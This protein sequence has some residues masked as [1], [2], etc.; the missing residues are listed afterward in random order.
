VFVEFVCMCVYVSVHVHMFVNLC[1]CVFV[2]L[3]RL[4]VNFWTLN[5]SREGQLT[6][7][8]LWFGYDLYQ[9]HMEPSLPVAMGF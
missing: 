6:Y 7:C 3:P 2:C 4:S 9:K 5:P 1:V 8:M